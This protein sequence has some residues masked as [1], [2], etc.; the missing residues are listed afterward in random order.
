MI[1]YRLRKLQ[2]EKNLYCL[3]CLFECILMSKRNFLFQLSKNL[4]DFDL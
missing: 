1:L 3:N 2:S 4:F